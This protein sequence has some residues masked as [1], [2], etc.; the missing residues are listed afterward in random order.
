MHVYIKQAARI[1]HNMWNLSSQ[2]GSDELSFLGKKEKVS[3]KTLKP[4]QTQ[5]EKCSYLLL[6][7]VGEK[8][9][10]NRFLV[11]SNSM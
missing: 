11:Q 1:F 2:Q 6:V 9:P 7:L 10:G 4:N 8:N 5:Q 3:E